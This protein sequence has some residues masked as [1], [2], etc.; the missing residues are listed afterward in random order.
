MPNKRVKVKQ[1]N[2]QSGSQSVSESFNEAD[3]IF[4][5]QQQL[6]TYHR[7]PYGMITSEVTTITEIQENLA[8]ESIIFI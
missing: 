2:Y 6:V 4:G 1:S 3:H 7:V 8:A 5:Q